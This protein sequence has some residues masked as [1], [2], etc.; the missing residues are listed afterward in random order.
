[1]EDRLTKN[2]VDHGDPAEEVSDRNNINI[3]NWTT[4]HF[5][6]ILAKNIAA[7]YPCPKTLP[8]AKLKSNKLI[9]LIVEISRQPNID[10]HTVVS[11]HCYVRTSTK[12]KSK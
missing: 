4:D 2:N 7:F 12:N 3:S 10:C 8:E 5:C 6:D 1:M 11:N 9:S